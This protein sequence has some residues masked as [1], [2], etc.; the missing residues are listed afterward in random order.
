MA[1]FSGR[2]KRPPIVLA[3]SQFRFATVGSI[4]KFV[5]AIHEP[6]RQTY[7]HRF[8]E[9]L[10]EVQLSAS[11]EASIQKNRRW[12]ILDRRKTSGYIVD[13]SM[14]VFRTTAYIDWDTFLRETMRGVSLLIDIARPAVIDRVGLRFVD[15]IKPT[16]A[17]P[18]ERQL[19][20]PLHGFR[21]KIDG[22]QP[23]VVQQLVRGKT[24]HGEL[25]FR[26]SQ[27]RHGASLPADLLDPH[28]TVEAPPKNEES[29]FIDIDH[30]KDNA[31]A[32]PDPAALQQLLMNLQDPMSHI[33]KDA[34]TQEAIELWN[35]P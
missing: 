18:L 13:S 28:I 12:Q 20:T 10:Q 34:V 31:D 25:M 8:P 21:P 4:D 3:L 33:F 27:A 2:L 7:P 19:E 32:D 14:I 5:E 24:P 35:M 17:L 9:D 1:K 30:F 29:V 15:L 22:F 6:I 16:T 26:C 11:G 23:Q